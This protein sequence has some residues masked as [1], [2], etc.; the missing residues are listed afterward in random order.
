MVSETNDASSA[1]VPETS[2]TDGKTRAKW[3]KPVLHK[4]DALAAENGSNNGGES[5]H[6]HHILS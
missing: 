5:T 2:K 1:D 4:F 3:E 6:T